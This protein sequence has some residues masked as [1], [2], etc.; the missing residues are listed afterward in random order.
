MCSSFLV[1]NS[2][3]SAAIW[4]P[5]TSSLAAPTLRGLGSACSTLRWQS[6]AAVSYEKDSRIQYYALWKTKCTGLRTKSGLRCVCARF[7]GFLL[8][9]VCREQCGQRSGSS[10]TNTNSHTLATNSDK[11]VLGVHLLH[12]H[13]STRA[14][15]PNTSPKRYVN[16]ADFCGAA[17]KCW[18]RASSGS[19]SMSPRGTRMG[20]CMP[21]GGCLAPV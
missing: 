1:S 12:E 14:P 3:P 19:W 7:V 15:S 18:R 5:G 8:E 6:M 17:S 13:L 11:C 16:G 10:D 4:L 20:K 9:Y 21:F 2:G